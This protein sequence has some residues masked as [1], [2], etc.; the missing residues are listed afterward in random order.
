MCVMCFTVLSTRAELRRKE[1]GG[2]KMTNDVWI[3][4]QYR[5]NQ[6]AGMNWRFPHSILQPSHSFFL[7]FVYC[8]D[9]LPVRITTHVIHTQKL[10][11]SSKTNEGKDSV[12]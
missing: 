11:A 7:T 5:N 4:C 1:R 2:K 3:A 10:N 12:Y 6:F 9:A 8:K